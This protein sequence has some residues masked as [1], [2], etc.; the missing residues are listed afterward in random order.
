MVMWFKSVRGYS[1]ELWRKGNF[2]YWGCL[3]LENEK[4]KLEPL[5]PPPHPPAP[6]WARV[7][8]AD[9]RD[10]DLNPNDS[11]YAWIQPCL[12]PVYL[13]NL[14]FTW[15]KYTFLKQFLKSSV[16]IRIIFSLWQIFCKQHSEVWNTLHYNKNILLLHQ[17]EYS[18]VLLSQ[19]QRPFSSSSDLG[20]LLLF[21]NK[22]FW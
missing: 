12:K 20:L 14:P 4:K 1:T 7:K 19:V 16:K 17:W 9:P 22:V 11:L 21:L 10:R 18:S 8:E 2:L 13:L 5:D 15:G 3:I 6:H